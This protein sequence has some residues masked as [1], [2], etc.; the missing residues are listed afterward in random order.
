MTPQLEL[1]EYYYRLVTSSAD[2]GVV[3]LH[4]SA[5]DIWTGGQQIGIR[6]CVDTHP[7]TGFDAAPVGVSAATMIAAMATATA[8]WERV[9][10][11]KYFYDSA[12]NGTCRVSDPAPDTRYIKISRDDTQP[13]VCAFGPQS[14]SSWTCPGLDGYTIGVPSDYVSPGPVT[15]WGGI[16]MHEL[17]HT[18][19]LH[20]EQLHT[21][22]G[23]CSTSST[24]DVTAAADLVSIMGYPLGSGG[25]ALTTP[26]LTALSE[27][28]GWT[29]RTFYGMPV[30]WYSGMAGLK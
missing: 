26:N 4:N 18:L 7:T 17:G 2:K 13:T 19:G 15:D 21:N 25:C 9:A 3:H 29:V 6:Y 5:D 1:S 11:I 23:G 27:G 22:G 8:A 20:H 24:R 12:N 10:N 14:H 30:S 28:D 16:M